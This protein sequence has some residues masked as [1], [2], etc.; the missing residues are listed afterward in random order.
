MTKNIKE[1]DLIGNDQIGRKFPL[2]WLVKRALLEEVL[3]EL[4]FQR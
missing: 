3:L 2:D 4:R 1:G